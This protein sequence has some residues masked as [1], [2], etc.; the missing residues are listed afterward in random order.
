MIYCSQSSEVQNTAKCYANKC[1]PGALCGSEFVNQEFIKWLK[2]DPEAFS[3]QCEALGTYL[4]G[5]S[6]PRVSHSFTATASSELSCQTFCV[7]ETL[8]NPSTFSIAG[9]SLNEC[10]K[11]ASEAFETIKKNF[12]LHHVG[13]TKPIFVVVN[14]KEGRPGAFLE[15]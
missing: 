4:K 14:G 1:Y 6:L 11:E 12:K 9:L 10:T 8:F 7:P 15:N 13:S 3:A 2:D 5:V